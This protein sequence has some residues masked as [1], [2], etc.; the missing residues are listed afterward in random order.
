MTQLDEYLGSARAA[1]E[2]GNTL[3]AR[4]Y[5][6]RAVNVAPD[7]LDVWRD[8][9][10]VTDLPAD[11]LRCLERI[12]ELAP[13]DLEAQSALDQLRDEIAQAEAAAAEAEAE[14]A[15]QALAERAA[16]GSPEQ[17]TAGGAVAEPVLLEMRQGITD[18]MRREWDQAVAEGKPLYCIDHPQRET[19]LRCNRCGAPVCTSCLVRTPVGLRCKECIRAQQASFFTALWYDYPVAALVALVL[20]V[21]G[22]VLA[23]MA[24]WFMVVVLSP[25]AGGLIGGAVHRAI[26]RRRGRGISALVGVCIVLGALA[27]LGASPFGAN[28]LSV[29]IYAAMATGAAMG[30]LRYGGRRR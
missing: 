24:T 20:A 10:A 18:D 17:S 14:A 16:D 28:L 27:A 11:R 2:A 22:A 13:E 12:V 9:L 8:L 3:V 23:S 29:G 7:R 5:L 19:N 4:G 21:L 26:G 25:F 15:A 30:V 1:L 6:R